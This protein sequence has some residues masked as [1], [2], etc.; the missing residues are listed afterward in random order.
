MALEQGV[1]RAG[2]TTGIVLLWSRTDSRFLLHYSFT[3]KFK[4]EPQRHKS[5]H[6][7]AMVL[8]LFKK[9]IFFHGGMK[10]K[11][12]QSFSNAA[13]GGETLALRET[14]GD[15][16][17]CLWRGSVWPVTRQS[18]SQEPCL[19][20]AET[21]SQVSYIRCGFLLSMWVHVLWA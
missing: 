7:A 2:S 6:S 13:S 3:C 9:Y 12:H 15:L 4:A 11:T 18:S 8:L 1:R 14:F 20:A 5:W 21:S 19:L 16:H 10:F 17:I